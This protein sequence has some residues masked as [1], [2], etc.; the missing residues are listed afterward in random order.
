[1]NKKS[2]GMLS[3]ITSSLFI[4]VVIFAVSIFMQYGSTYIDE[5]FRTREENVKYSVFTNNKS[6]VEGSIRDIADYKAQYDLAKDKAE[7]T[8]IESVVKDRFSN[9]DANQIESSRLRTWFI[10]VRGY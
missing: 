9:F 3:V 6:H 7:Q 1:M 8:I 10:G 4:A 2:G 5:L